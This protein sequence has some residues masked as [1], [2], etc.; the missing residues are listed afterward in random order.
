MIILNGRKDST[1][2]VALITGNPRRAILKLSSHLIVAM[3]LTSTYNLI[4]AIWVSGLGGNA[5]AA[6]GFVTPVYMILVGLSNG[7]GAGATSAISRCI[8][9]KKTKRMNNTAIHAIIL[10]LIISLFITLLLEFSLRD[11]L[12]ML[13][14]KNALNL[15]LTYGRI[16]FAGTIFILFTGS[17]YGILRGEGDTKRT[18]H[19]MIIAAIINMILDPILIYS[20]KMGIAGAAWATL[21]SQALV[22]AI[23]IYWFLYKKD[24]FTRLS[25]KYFKANFKVAKSILEVALPASVEFFVIST[26]TAILNIIFVTV[27]GTDAV[28]V[29]SAG[30]RVVMIGF[31]PLISIGTGTITVAGVAYGARK[32]NNLSIAHNY[33]IKIGMLVAIATSI[34]TFILAPYISMIFTY[35][36]QARHLAPTITEFLRIM[37]LF[38]IFIPPGLMSNSIFQGIGKG[39]TSLILTI[40]RQLLFIVI[41]A[42]ILAIMFNLGQRGAWWGVVAGDIVGSMIAYLWARIYIKRLQQLH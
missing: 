25:W 27:A 10:T 24:T 19:A 2:G 39:T 40:I 37:C 17:A 11:L 1:E 22:S 31:V 5:L 14:A 36:P 8:G 33:S 30:W 12:L 3:L 18:M 41:F 6:I 35:S 28:A 34:L 32:Y 20:L 15:S 21:A 13:G 38:Y 9:A 7:L 42:Y 16:V 26:G 23:I 29:Y 4:D